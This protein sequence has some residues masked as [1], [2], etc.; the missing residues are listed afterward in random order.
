M[1]SGSFFKRPA[2]LLAFA[3]CSV[4][5]LVTILGRLAGGPPAQQKRVAL[6]QETGTKAYPAFAPDGQRI[7]Y[8][9]RSGSKVEPFHI[10]IRV[11]SPKFRAVR[12]SNSAPLVTADT[13][14]QLTSG[15]GSDIGPVWSPDGSRI[16]F[17]RLEEGRTAYIVTGVDGGS[18]QQVIAF[19]ASAADAQP[20][21]GVAWMPDGRS[22]VVVDLPEKQPG[23]LAVVPVGGGEPKRITSPP[24]GSEGDSTPAIA[25][26]GTALAFVRSS[27]SDGA[28]IFLC[29][30]S[31][32][33]VRRLT[34]DDRPIRGISWTRDSRDLLYAANR[35]GNG[36][37]LVRVPGYGGAPREIS[38]AGRQAENPAV[39]PAGNRLAF[40]ESSTVSS[41]WRV[42][43]AEG[44]SNEERPLIHSRGHESYPA[45]SPDGK[46]IADVSSQSG[47]DELWISDADGGNRVAV[48]HLNGPQIRRPQWSGDGSS[49]VFDA[50]GD[51]GTDL[52]LVTASAGAAPKRLVAGASGGALSP[53]GKH[54]YY[55]A[56]GQIWKAAANG[57]NPEP[58][59]QEMGAGQPMLSPDGKTV[60]YRFR[61]SI[62]QVPAAGGQAEESFI[63]HTGMFLGAM[64]IGRKGA[65]Y[66]QF[67]RRGSMICFYDF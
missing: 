19:P 67:N 22:L 39:A 45:Y 9:A 66:Q 62:W 38:I 65:Y 48:T 3:L 43:L 27:G 53:D 34:F 42:K 46:K 17:T 29:D 23:F 15:E 36:Y 50:S 7:A 13:P 33:A 41:I 26:D 21:P 64:H 12:Q 24:E 20:E 56:H 28:D 54:V 5:A 6:S 40:A 61:R 2:V 14:R 63:P 30:L 35:F 60:Y 1:L 49:I 37:R 11:V 59:T 10:W 47:S 32:G 25:P 31:G 18:E 4:G 58:L 51:Q 57:G 52:Y 8:S 44:G 55:Q 16:A